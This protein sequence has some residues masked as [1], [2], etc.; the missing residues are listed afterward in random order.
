MPFSI[1]Y[2]SIISHC[3][4][5]EFYSIFLN[6]IFQRSK[7]FFLLFFYIKDEF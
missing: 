7:N 2:K 6:Y 4:L 3:Y 5:N 1:I